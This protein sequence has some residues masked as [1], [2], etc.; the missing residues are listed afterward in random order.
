MFLKFHHLLRFNVV[1]SL[2]GIKC[3]LWGFS[4]Y[5]ELFHVI[6]EVFTIIETLREKLVLFANLYPIQT[7]YIHKPSLF[8]KPVMSTNYYRALRGI[9]V[10]TGFPLFRSSA[11]LYVCPSVCM[12]VCPEAPG[13]SFWAKDLKFGTQ[14]P[15]SLR[16]K[17][18]F[19]FFEFRIFKGL[20]TRF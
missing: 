4:H 16:K 20:F 8:Y 5:E 11:C 14:H 13:H 17:L 2:K 1:I 18:N 3:H 12:Y 9:S 7:C 15:W 10:S 6:C 19:Y